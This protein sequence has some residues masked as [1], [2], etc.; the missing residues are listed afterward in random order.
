MI[1]AGGETVNGMGGEALA[2]GKRCYRVIGAIDISI[3]VNEINWFRF[4]HGPTITKGKFFAWLIFQDCV[5]VYNGIISPNEAGKALLWANNDP[6][7][8][9]EKLRE[10]YRRLKLEE[11]EES[12]VTPEP[13][14]K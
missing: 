4:F 9:V 3:T 12:F 11:K 2:V 8:V 7:F 6:F 14:K 13:I 5:E 1:L 10:I